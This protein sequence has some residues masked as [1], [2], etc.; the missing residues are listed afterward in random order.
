MALGLVGCLLPSQ[1]IAEREAGRGR[2]QRGQSE[3][4]RRGQKTQK[5]PSLVYDPLFPL[6]NS[7]SQKPSP[8]NEGEEGNQV[9]WGGGVGMGNPFQKESN[10]L[11]VIC[12]VTRKHPS[13]G[14]QLSIQYGTL[15]GRKWGRGPSEPLTPQP[16]SPLPG[17]QGEARSKRDL[18]IA[19]RLRRTLS[20]LLQEGCLK[21]CGS[22]HVRE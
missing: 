7:P 8:R 11:T 4:D 16:E 17:T 3:W 10:S 6:P 15:G 2:E 13:N 1:V 19:P 18:E 21:N 22:R 14:G 12:S 9:R 5:C 20:L